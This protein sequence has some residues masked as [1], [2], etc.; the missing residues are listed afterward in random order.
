VLLVCRYEWDWKLKV[1]GKDP[2]GGGCGLFKDN[3]PAFVSG[4]KEKGSAE[5]PSG[6]SIVRGYHVTPRLQVQCLIGNPDRSIETCDLLY[7]KP[8]D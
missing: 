7:V 5:N 1:N 2:L 3:I 4:E 8:K 6:Q